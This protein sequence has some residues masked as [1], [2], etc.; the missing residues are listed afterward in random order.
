ML[1]LKD[2]SV[3]QVKE[4]I[5]SLVEIPM[6]KCYLCL[7]QLNE[8]E[9]AEAAGI[10]Q[11]MSAAELL[12]S[13]KKVLRPMYVLAVAHDA[14]PSVQPLDRVRASRITEVTGVQIPC[15]IRGYKVVIIRDYDV[16][17]VIKS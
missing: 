4:L 16:L 6:N 9:E 5:E 10:S 8:Q 15:N 13:E 17:T 1:E 3:E 11:N 12:K 14:E 7:K 2:P